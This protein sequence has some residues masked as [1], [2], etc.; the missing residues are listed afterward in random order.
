[1]LRV[2]VTALICK[3]V[4]GCDNYDLFWFNKRP[5]TEKGQG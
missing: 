2:Y 4:S 1:M 3:H 5:V